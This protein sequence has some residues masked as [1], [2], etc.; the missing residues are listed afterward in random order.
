[1][2]AKRQ[3]IAFD[4]FVNGEKVCRAGVGALGV[5]T[6]GISWV[7]SAVKPPGVKRRSP[8]ELFL[9]VGGLYNDAAGENVHP[10]WAHVHLSPGDHV[11]IKVVRAASFDPPLRVSVSTQA[12]I[13]RGEER[14]LKHVGK[15][16]GWVKRRK[17][18]AA[19]KARV[20]RT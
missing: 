16:Y 20:G 5:I 3:H 2:A 4:V 12:E 18:R 10:H 8:E 6:A 14:Y 11:S 7:R 9:Q 13:K 19:R 15:K 1:L 17:V